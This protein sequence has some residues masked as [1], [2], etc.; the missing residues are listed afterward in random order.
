M[1]ST[2]MTTL[3]DLAGSE[4]QLVQFEKGYFCCVIEALLGIEAVQL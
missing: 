4:E 1:T 2:T 3:A